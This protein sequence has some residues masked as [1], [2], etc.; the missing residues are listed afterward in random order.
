MFKDT[1][2]K[3]LEAVIHGIRK[4]NPDMADSIARELE[5]SRD[6]PIK[7]DWVSSDPFSPLI[8]AAEG[9]KNLR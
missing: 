2:I 9:K 3:A 4:H 6:A 1:T 8:S 5:V 7:A